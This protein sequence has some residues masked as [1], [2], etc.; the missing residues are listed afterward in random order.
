MHSNWNTVAHKKQ[1]LHYLFKMAYREER[2]RYDRWGGGGTTRSS[3]SSTNP[4]DDP[5]S[6]RDSYS[7]ASRY[8]PSSEPYSASH[9]DS[10]GYDSYDGAGGGGGVG[11]GVPEDDYDMRI[12]AAYRR[13]EQSSG[14]SLRTLNETVRMGVETT[15]ELETQ[16]ETLD[17]TE[18]RLDEIDVDLDKSKRHMRIIKSPF[19]GIANYFAKK[20]PISEVTDPKMPASSSQ[21]KASSRSRKSGPEQQQSTSYDSTGNQIVDK[22]LEEMEKAL[23]QLRGI[24]E[25]IGDQL[26]DSDS[27]IDRIRVKMDRDDV[28]MK[29]INRDMRRELR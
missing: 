7:S 22:N 15:E 12:Q 16:A 20:K 8:G 2:G 6:A 3:A 19:G 1:Q 5:P 23:H 27:Q 26:D 17:R 25:L 14:S 10:R 13:M 21:S 18:R 24:G 29:G 11:Y 4:F 9:Y 28:K